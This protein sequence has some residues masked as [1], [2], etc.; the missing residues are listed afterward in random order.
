MKKS[1]FAALLFTLGFAELAHAVCDHRTTTCMTALDV[2][3]AV[4]I[5]GPVTHTAVINTASS[6]PYAIKFSSRT[7]AIPTGTPAAV[8][9]LAV[10]LDNI[11]Y[12]STSTN[13][14]GWQKVG[15]Q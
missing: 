3:G 8:G 15:A 2:S 13:L 12:I 14:A 4:A 7:S 9:I 6:T 10:G 11:L 5:G 1:L